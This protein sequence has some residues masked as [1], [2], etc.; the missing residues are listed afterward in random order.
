MI[1]PVKPFRLTPDVLIAAY[2]NGIFPMDVDGVIQW[3]SPDPR[4]IIELDAL[5]VSRRLGRTVRSGRFEIRIDTCFERI[6]RC[7]ADRPEGTWINEDIVRAYTDLHEMGLAHSVETWRGAELAGGLYGVALRGAFFGE[8]MFHRQRDASKVALTALVGRMKN[9]GMTLLDVQ[10]VT[11]HL[12][13]LGAKEIR[14]SEYLRRLK[15]ALELDTR[16]GE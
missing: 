10:W 12:E 5:H 8:S 4:A 7:C 15:A 9:R 6:M 16:F 13:R 1:G 11:P 2:C 14:R 3:F